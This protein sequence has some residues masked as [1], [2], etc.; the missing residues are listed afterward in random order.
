MGSWETIVELDCLA[1]RS[2]CLRQCLTGIEFTQDC[3]LCVI[4]GKPG[5]AKGI[6][7]LNI[8][9]LLVVPASFFISSDGPGVVATQV[10]VVSFRFD[11]RGIGVRRR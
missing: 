6:V 9:S 4:V 7:G 1:S 8:D 5:P 11:V 2:F 3:P 10:G